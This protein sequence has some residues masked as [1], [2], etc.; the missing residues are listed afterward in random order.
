MKITN[1]QLRRVISEVLKGELLED[2]KEI[3]KIVR[4]E[5]KDGKLTGKEFSVEEIAAAL[6]EKEPQSSG[7]GFDG[8]NAALRTLSDDGDLVLVKGKLDSEDAR[9]KVK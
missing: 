2:P 7:V 1:R 3:V 6:E 8:L 5:I 4:D 9:Y